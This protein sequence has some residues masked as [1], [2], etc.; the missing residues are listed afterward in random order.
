MQMNVKPIPTL[1]PRI[2]EIRELTARIINHD[3]LP[4]ENKLWAGWRDGANAEERTK[5]RELRESVKAKVKQAGLW[6]PHLPPEYGGSGL[7]F[8]E[9]A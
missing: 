7:G 5:S 8:L 1:D 6:A 9:H 3:I 4:N 2:N